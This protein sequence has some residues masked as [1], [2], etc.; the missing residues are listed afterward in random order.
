MGLN[1][2]TLVLT[3]ESFSTTRHIDRSTDVPLIA[4]S[5]NEIEHNVISQ[6]DIP[7]NTSNATIRIDE[8]GDK[9]LLEEEVGKNVIGDKTEE[10]PSFSEWTQKRLEEAEK[11]QQINSSKNIGSNGEWALNTFL[12]FKHHLI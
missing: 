12:D 9:L 10:I 1:D 4:T 6:I 8:T 7:Q 5:R 11:N 3:P 2:S